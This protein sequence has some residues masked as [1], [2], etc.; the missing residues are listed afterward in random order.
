MTKPKNEQM[1]VRVPASLKRALKAYLRKTDS[2]HFGALGA[3]VTRCIKLG[4]AQLTRELDD[5]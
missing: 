4:L 2:D 1:N 5:A 3:L